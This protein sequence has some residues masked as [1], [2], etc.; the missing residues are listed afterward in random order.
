M[1]NTQYNIQLEQLCS[2]LCLGE[3]LCEPEQLT[4]G[5]LHRMY[6]V[7]TTSGK[8]AV[9]ALNPQVM[10]RPAAKSNITNGERIAAVAAE[11]IPA[12]P[13]KRFANTFIQEMDGQS[14]LVY[15]WAKGKSL[16]GESITTAHCETI[17][18]LLG[19][20][21]RIDF[22]S[23]G[24]QNP[25][26]TAEALVD[27][28]GY[29]RKGQQASSPWAD[30]LSRNMDDLYE[31][32]RRYLA[33]MQYLARPLVIG[34][35]DIDPKNVLWHDGQ[36]LIIDW[37]SAG[38]LH[39]AHEFIVYALYWSDANGTANKEKFMAFLNGYLRH[40]VLDGFDWSIVMGAGLHPGWLAYS[41]KRSLGIESADAAEQ[42]M[43]TEHVLG[44]IDYFKR[45]AASIS[46]IMGWLNA[47]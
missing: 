6:A 17:G 47:R 37:E 28:S 31:W 19:K 11:Y 20:L 44:T 26:S 18:R 10:L 21:H 30:K 39:P 32:N 45:Y 15:D 4:G 46:Q 16:Y 41:L 29:L 34:H 36:P 23:L 35:G 24:I 9:K 5:L 38:Y 3:L 27:W 2:H 33:S 40:A 13:A 14:Y 22:S 12:L 7:E 8:Y 25:V 1:E 42:Q 43:G